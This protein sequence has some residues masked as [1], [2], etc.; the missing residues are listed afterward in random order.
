MKLRV[1]ILSLALL[2]SGCV[3]SVKLNEVFELTLGNTVDIEGT[4]VSVKFVGVEDLRCTNHDLCED[5][6]EAIVELLVSKGNE[7]EKV[8]VVFPFFLD[9]SEPEGSVRTYGY[10]IVISA[11]NPQPIS[12]ES[13]DQSSYIATIVVKKPIALV[14]AYWGL[15]HLQYEGGQ[16]QDVEL[17]TSYYLSF[18]GESEAK[19][20]ANCNQFSAQY[21]NDDYQLNFISPQFSFD[22]CDVDS[23]ENVPEQVAWFKDVIS[24]SEAYRIR[25]NKLV[26]T[27][28]ESK[29]A[30]FDAVIK[31]CNLEQTVGDVDPDNCMLQCVNE[32]APTLS[33]FGTR[34]TQQCE[35][36]CA[37][38]H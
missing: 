27:S 19:G 23:Q 37:M 20:S 36:Y 21:E 2:V 34:L 31:T 28:S 4:S 29:Q 7:S 33:C 35:I 38:Q 3:P 17:N 25:D 8:E 9:G 10:E 11:L 32:A 5:G 16:P 26:I 13:P 1:L 15:S 14:E 18:D 6:G 22:P 30:V 12:E 24:G